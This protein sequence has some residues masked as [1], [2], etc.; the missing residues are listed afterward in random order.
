MLL[1]QIPPLPALSK[2]LAGRLAAEEEDAYAGN[3]STKKGL[4]SSLKRR[5]RAGGA[6]RHTALPVCKGKE[7]KLFEERKQLRVATVPRQRRA[8]NHRR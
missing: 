4:L 6:A 2:T 3:S 1:L 7:Q 5:A 8:C